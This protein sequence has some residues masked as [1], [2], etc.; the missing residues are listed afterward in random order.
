MPFRFLSTMLIMLALTSGS[1][2][3]DTLQFS[4]AWIQALTGNMTW[5]F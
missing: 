2:A 1:Q 4:N 5:R 3:T